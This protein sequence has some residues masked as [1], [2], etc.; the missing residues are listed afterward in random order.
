MFFCLFFGF[1][2]LPAVEVRSAVCIAVMDFP[3][4]GVP[5][6][7]GHVTGELL[8]TYFSEGGGM[9]VVESDPIKALGG[10]SRTAK[11]EDNYEQ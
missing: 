9:E 6:H 8:R 11:G 7:L 2:T 4:N 1:I 3:V 5:H 10:E